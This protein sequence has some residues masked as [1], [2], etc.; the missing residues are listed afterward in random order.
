MRM[1]FRSILALTL[2]LSARAVHAQAGEATQP[3]GPGLVASDAGKTNAKEKQKAQ[4]L[5]LL[6]HTRALS[7][8][9]PNES[10][11]LTVLDRVQERLVATK[12]SELS[13]LLEFDP[14]LSNLTETLARMEGRVGALQAPV[15]LCDPSRKKELFL[16][17]LDVLDVDGQG[18]VQAKICEKVASEEDTEGG[19]SQA[20]VATSLGLLAARSMHDLIVVC[21][22][23]LSRTS[24][25]A[26][27][28]RFE[29]LS[30]ELAGVQAGVQ[31]S[32]RSVKSE[33]TQAMSVV[34]GQMVDVSSVQAKQLEDL[35]VRLEIER[36]LQQGTP[37][38]SLYL[39]AANGGRLEAVRAIVDETIRNVLR[40]GESANQASEKLAAADDQFKAG[41]FKQA[42]RLYSDA[43]KAAVALPSKPR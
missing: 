1:T 25:D 7:R 3:S 32:V 4:L 34:A 30:V 5:T 10:S 6:D 23:S 16:V 14:Y 19:L 2:I 36:A 42:F 24:P 40:S 8:W 15:E 12:E 28:A 33:L 38:G 37:Y 35:T 39:P 22:P 41:H 17:Y 21:D 26:G 11:F 20:C 43:Y 9:M 18:Q 29:K 13:P 31:A 27:G